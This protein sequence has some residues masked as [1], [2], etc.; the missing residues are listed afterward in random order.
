[1]VE[2]ACDC[3]AGFGIHHSHI[4]EWHVYTDAPNTKLTMPG[5]GRDTG[6]VRLWVDWKKVARAALIDGQEEGR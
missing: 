3:E 2:Y 5:N 4:R 6:W 1:M